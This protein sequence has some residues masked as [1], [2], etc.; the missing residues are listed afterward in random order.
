MGTRAL[1]LGESLVGRSSL[2]VAGCAALFAEASKEGRA[3]GTGGWAGCAAA[4]SGTAAEAVGL[5]VA[6]GVSAAGRARAGV[7]LP[8]EMT[9]PSGRTETVFT[10]LGSGNG[11]GAA[12]AA[13]VEPRLVSAM[14]RVG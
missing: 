3:W 6:T 13:L 2:G 5:S 1:D 14:L 12:G 9:V 10:R 4:S 7:L 8:V 11:A